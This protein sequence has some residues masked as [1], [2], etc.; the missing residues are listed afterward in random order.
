MLRTQSPR[1]DEH[2]IQILAPVIA[3]IIW[4]VGTESGRRVFN[5]LYIM[6]SDTLAPIYR[7]YF[8]KHDVLILG[9]MASGKSSLIS[10]LRT[11]RPYEL[12][13]DGTRQPPG[14]TFGLVILS[15]SRMKMGDDKINE[16]TRIRKDVSGDPMAQVDIWPSLIA[17]INPHGIIY[18]VIG[19]AS[20]DIIEVQF[21]TFVESLL[22]HYMAGPRSLKTIAILLNHMDKWCCD[23]S[24]KLDL[25]LKWYHLIN[26]YF[27]KELPAFKAIDI[28]VI[29]THLNIEKNDWPEMMMAL[30]QFASSLKTSRP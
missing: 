11:G 24:A 26:N 2:M 22:A 13:Q 27:K 4:G 6:A 21:K 12:L 18:M 3:A 5:N 25:Q 20:P 30:T 1:V 15:E 9:E 7:S 16:W 17:D 28:Q 14:K 19:S 10:L 23:N 8:P 29:S